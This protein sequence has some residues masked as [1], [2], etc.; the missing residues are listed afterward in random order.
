MLGQVLWPYLLELLVID[1]YSE[2]L[3]VLCRSVHNIASRKRSSSDADYNIDFVIHGY[4][5]SFLKVFNCIINSILQPH[6]DCQ[7]SLAVLLWPPCVADA[8]IIFS[9]CG[10]FFLSSFFPHLISAVAG[11]TSTIHSHTV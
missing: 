2:S 9:S 8:D 1:D 4:F 5:I 6:C 10:F 11:W 3:G 7:L